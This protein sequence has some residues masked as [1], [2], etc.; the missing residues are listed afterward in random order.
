M[1]NYWLPLGQYSLEVRLISFYIEAS[2]ENSRCQIISVC[3]QDHRALASAAVLVFLS[4]SIS[5]VSCRPVFLW[6]VPL[7]Q[8]WSVTDSFSEWSF[9]NTVKKCINSDDWRWRWLKTSFSHKMITDKTGMTQNLEASGSIQSSFKLMLL[10]CL[11]T[12]W[13]VYSLC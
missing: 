2:L 7:R 12:L 10:I 11:W 4:F 3:I 1:S 8:S 9:T 6:A 13:S 5:N